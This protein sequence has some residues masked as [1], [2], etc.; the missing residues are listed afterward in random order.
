MTARTDARYALSVIKTFA[1][2][3]T[4]ALF[5]GHAVKG[6]AYEVQRRA[7]AKLHFVDAAKRLDDLRIPP[8]NRLEALKV[9]RAGQHSIRINDRWRICFMWRAGEAWDVEVVDYHKG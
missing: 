2:K 6:I 9:D 5:A 8:G 1:D 7:R 4:A 3:R